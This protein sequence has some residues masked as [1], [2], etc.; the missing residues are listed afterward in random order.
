MG[1]RATT[2]NDRVARLAMEYGIALSAARQYHDHDEH[3][4]SRHALSSSLASVT[5]VRIVPL[6]M[7]WTEIPA[8]KES[9]F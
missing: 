8:R 1:I 4:T 6:A 5:I 7:R 2:Q 3:K 9:H